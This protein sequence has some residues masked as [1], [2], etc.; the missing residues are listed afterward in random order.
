MARN[1]ASEDTAPSA[2]GTI[3]YRFKRGSTIPIEV[4]VLGCTGDVTSNPGVVGSVAVFTDSSC[5]R[6][7]DASATPID[8]NGIGAVEERWKKSAVI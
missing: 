1:G 5:A 7:S 3:K 2:G 6:A 8:F 4:H